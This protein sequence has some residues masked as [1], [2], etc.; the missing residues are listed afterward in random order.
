MD[1]LKQQG[2]TLIEVLVAM[3]VLGLGLFAAAGL[4][5]QALQAT[6]S[7]LRTTQAA[8][9]AQGVFEQVRAGE[10][11]RNQDPGR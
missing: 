6:E 9:L 10:V 3:A 1:G 8:Y 2:M 4:Q 5:V 7:A 11:L